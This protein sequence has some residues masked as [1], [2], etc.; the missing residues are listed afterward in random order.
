[1]E[2]KFNLGEAI[3]IFRYQIRFQSVIENLSETFSILARHGS[4][5]TVLGS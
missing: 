3:T 2:R 4:F 5:D 1:M